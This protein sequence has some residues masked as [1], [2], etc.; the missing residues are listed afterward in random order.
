MQLSAPVHADMTRPE[1]SDEEEEASSIKHRIDEAG[2]VAHGFVAEHS[3][4]RPCTAPPA[5]PS[6][7]AN[8]QSQPVPG[9]N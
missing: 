3:Q 2:D 5:A 7:Y 9:L 1:Y 4:V 6:K 8:G